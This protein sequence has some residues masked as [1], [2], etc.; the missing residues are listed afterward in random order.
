MPLIIAL[1]VGSSGKQ[2]E[3]DWGMKDVYCEVASKKGKKG[4]KHSWERIAS[5]YDINLTKSWPV[6]WGA[7][8]QKLSVKMFP[9]WADMVRAKYPC[10]IQELSGDFS[11]IAC[12]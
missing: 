9:Y 8:K 10:F 5:D 3:T 1:S 11:G 2:T 4:R 12:P 7:L 6:Q